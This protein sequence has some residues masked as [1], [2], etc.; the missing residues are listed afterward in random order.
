MT[1][2]STSAPPAARAPAAPAA[3]KA[4]LYTRF[5]PR[6]ELGAFAA[7]EPN[8]LTRP[9]PTGQP[10]RAADGGGVEAAAQ[11]A[12]KV[13]QAR[14][15]G[16]QEGY[17][18]GLV[19]L[20]GFKQTF[21]HQ[22]TLQIGALLKSLGEQLDGLQGQMAQ[23]L[24]ASA[25]RIA[26]QAVRSELQTRPELIAI[27]AQEAL[28]TL[29]LSARHITLRVHPDD[30]PLVADGAGDLL[31]ARSARLVADPTIARGGCVVESDIGVID[32]SLDTRWRRAA[33]SLG[34]EVPWTDAGPS[35]FASLSP[36]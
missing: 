35:S 2:N 23:T 33:A 4:S 28:D 11:V 17:R 7:W 24:C 9:G 21:A 5:I 18:D 12:E 15:A 13:R 27:V 22:T 34:G 19:A 26:R 8:D 31:D 32:A 1:T 20:E 29:V 16:Y 10:P 3:G 25:T 14:Q 36:T 30:H 6:E